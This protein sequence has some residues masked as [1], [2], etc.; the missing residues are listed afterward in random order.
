MAW[1]E[2]GGNKNPWDRRPGQAPPDLDDI[3]R[4]WQRRLGAIFGG[5]SGTRAPGGRPR[6]NWGAIGLLLLAVWGA[7]GFYQ[8]DAAERGVVTRFGRYVQTTNEGLRWHWPWPVESVQIVNVAE[9][10]AIEDKTSMLTADENLVD[11]NMAVQFLR[12]DPL[13]FVFRVRDPEETL[14]DV[15]ES[16]IREIIGQSKLDFVLGAGRQEI[17]ERTK[18]LIQR[19]LDVYQTG[20]TVIS[21]NLTAVSVPDPV[22]PSQKDAIKAREDRD[23]FS[24]EAQAYAN[25]VVP[26][27]R[28]T[29]ARQLQDAQAYRTRIIAES[30]G[31]TSRFAQLLDAYE[32]APNVTRE[33]LYIETIE[34]VLGRSHKVLLDTGPGSNVI[35]LPLDKLME[36]SSA[37]G[38]DGTTGVIATPGVRDPSVS[39]E[40]IP[41]D[42]RTR[43]DR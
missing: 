6:L 24:Q 34:T 4:N 39:I 21:V 12:A 43:G 30:E 3:V 37:S 38:S 35:Y 17:T 18:E 1:N 19:M 15:S 16:A 36:K 10:A 40:N 25:D 33:R 13:K 2:P 9:N 27:A 20:I 26:K 11:I 31:E 5:G 23:R 42:P 28:G 7:T 8:V 14:T 41:V 22:A 29:A 32:R